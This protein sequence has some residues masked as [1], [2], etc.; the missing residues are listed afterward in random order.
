[1]SEDEG[2][3]YFSVMTQ[4]INIVLIDMSLVSVGFSVKFVFDNGPSLLEKLQ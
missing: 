3:S 1:M 2:I 4:L